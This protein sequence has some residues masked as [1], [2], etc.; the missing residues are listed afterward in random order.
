MILFIGQA[1]PKTFKDY[2]FQGTNFYRWFDRVGL[3]TDFIRA[4]SHIT[5]ILTTYSGVNSKGAGDRL[6]TPIEVQENLPRLMNLIQNLQPR[7]IVP[8][9][10]FSIETIFGIQNINL[11]NYIGHSFEIQPY[12][13]LNQ[14]QNIIPLPHPSG[15]SRWTYQKNHKEL[16]NQALELVKESFAQ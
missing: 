14:L 3:S 8:I 4:H 9:G 6:P 11:E 13:Q 10:K 15:L 12:Q 2:E 16:L 7:A 1:Y 5:A